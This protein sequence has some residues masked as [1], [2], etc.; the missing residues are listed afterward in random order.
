[1]K[2]GINEILDM[3]DLMVIFICP[4]LDKESTFWA[5]MAQKIKTV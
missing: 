3:L 5:N 4:A 1:M 2:V